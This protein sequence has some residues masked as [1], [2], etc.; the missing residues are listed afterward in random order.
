MIKHL[1]DTCKTQLAVWQ[2]APYTNYAR[3]IFF[4][5]DHVPTR[6]CSCTIDSMTGQLDVDELGRELPC[7]EYLWDE[8]G[9]EI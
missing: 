8:N 3:E 2:Y 4:C 5:E 9:Y 1:C 7:C 6:G